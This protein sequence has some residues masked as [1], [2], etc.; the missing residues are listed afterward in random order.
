MLARSGRLPKRSGALLALACAAAALQAQHCAQK[1]RRM[2]TG[3]RLISSG[4]KAAAAMVEHGQGRS[5]SRRCCRT[6]TN[7]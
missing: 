2:G 4:G 5:S 1:Q 6:L 3:S 7:G